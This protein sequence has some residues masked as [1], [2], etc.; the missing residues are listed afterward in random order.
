MKSLSLALLLIAPF[1]LSL[2]QN[3]EYPS[4][5]Y[6]PSP[7]P[8][9]QY[10][11]YEQPA[12]GNYTSNSEYDQLLT[13]GSLEGHYAYNDFR[14]DDEL[15]GEG[16]FG[17]DLKLQLMKPLFLHFGLDRLTSED[18]SA[19]KL[20]ITSFSAGG[21][22]YIPIGS[23]FHLFGEIGFSYDYTG[24]DLETINT[25]EF[26]VYVRPGI[27]IAATDSL[28]LSLSVLF[29]STDN[30]NNRVIEAAAYYAI[31]DWLDIM[32]GLDFAEEVN[33]YHL[34]GRWRW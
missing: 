14:G 6:N 10:A 3:Y 26:A 27:R 18:A 8:S 5:P 22:A 24:G 21:G 23:R 34:G 30:L 1:S 4:D 31:F 15:E 13:Y 7:Q 20:E 33:S 25:D 12:S 16:G 9:R 28:E 19:R 11:G 29:N 17:A 32:V 2:A